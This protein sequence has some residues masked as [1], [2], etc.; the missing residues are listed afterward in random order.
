MA[1]QV[2]QLAAYH[3]RLMLG[4]SRD[5]HVSIIRPSTLQ[6]VRSRCHPRTSSDLAVRKKTVSCCMSPPA[7]EPVGWLWWLVPN[8]TDI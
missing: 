2:P 4:Y 5:R 3:R 6:H 8:V 1:S 7:I